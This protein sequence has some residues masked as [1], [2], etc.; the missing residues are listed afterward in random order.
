MNKSFNDLS[1]VAQYFRE[2]MA[3]NK[4][5]VLFAHNGTGKT[6]LSMEFREIGK[7]S[8]KGRGD[9]LYF[10]AFTEDLF[11]WDNDLENNELRV[12]KINSVSKFFNGLK[13]Y[14]MESRIGKFLNRYVDFDFK[15]DMEKWQI[16]FSCKPQKG[17]TEW[18]DNIKISRG[19]ENIFIWCFFLAILEMVIDDTPAYSWVKYIYIDDP[20]SSLDEHNA[21]AVASNLAQLLK[22]DS[23]NREI[24]AIISTHHPLFFNVLF[25]EFK[26]NRKDKFLSYTLSFLSSL[27]KYKLNSTT[28][29]P[30]FHHIAMLKELKQAADTGELYSYHFNILRN[31]LEKS[32]IFHGHSKFS[33]SL[34]RD[35][36]DKEDPDG[37]LF[38]RIINILNHG[39]YSM[40]EPIEMVQENK[41][42][43]KKIL[44]KFLNAYPFNQELFNEVTEE[45]N[46]P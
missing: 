34:T 14:D 3:K 9:T 17:S 4:F 15:I 22:S 24:H 23:H 38:A 25:N 20:I 45:K 31:L 46:A 21:I 29:T 19:E 33:E 1:E 39:G 40:F 16:T 11:T 2:Q 6:R 8:T 18:I 27:S 35:V 12:L 7:N 13:D 37:V 41:I 36:N 26:S 10:N 42:H 28:D 32:A 30:F 44:D 43:F 5:I